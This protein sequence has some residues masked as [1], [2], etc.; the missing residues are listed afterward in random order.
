MCVIEEARHPVRAF[1]PPIVVTQYIICTYTS[2]LGHCLHVVVV[3][4]SEF[5]NQLFYIL[6][7]VL[8]FMILF[9]SLQEESH[10]ASCIASFDIL[11]ISSTE[12][13]SILELES[14]VPTVNEETKSEMLKRIKLWLKELV[15]I[16]VLCI[17]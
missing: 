8:S 12:Y 9:L 16:C 6:I 4:G 2:S 14:C 11:I 17:W 3:I 7:S 5:H 15:S 10:A 1:Q 13:H